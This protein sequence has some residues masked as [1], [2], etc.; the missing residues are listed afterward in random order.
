MREA[1][2]RWGIYPAQPRTTEG[3]GDQ[4][5]R[6]YGAAGLT[7]RK[8]ECLETP[9][10]TKRTS[11]SSVFVY[12]FYF[13][14]EPI[15]NVL[16]SGVQRSDLVIHAYIYIFCFFIHIYIFTH[17]FFHYRLLQEIDYSSLYYIVN[18]CCFLHIFFEL[19]I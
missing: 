12:N 9:F 15:Y 2:T 13:I 6:L 4:G 3:S 16:V 10:P 14:S 5:V 11:F 1:K 7:C 8:R 18:L 17:S 19:E